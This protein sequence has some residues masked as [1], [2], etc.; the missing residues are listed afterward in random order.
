MCPI[1]ALLKQ[2]YLLKYIYFIVNTHISINGVPEHD[3]KKII[4]VIIN[5]EHS[6]MT[7]I[8]QIGL[9]YEVNTRE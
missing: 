7:N 2:L 1:Q 3:P 8:L 4:L 6:S 9:Y 5:S